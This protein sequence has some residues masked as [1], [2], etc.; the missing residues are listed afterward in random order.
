MKTKRIFPLLMFMLS[1]TF[2]SCSKDD[3]P[4]EEM[5]LGIHKI[6]L[7]VV[8]NDVTDISIAI[9]SNAF[10]NKELA[11]TRQRMGSI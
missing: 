10:N 8:S 2:S 1:F 9:A 5:T 4:I 7:N 11:P 3:D 6:V